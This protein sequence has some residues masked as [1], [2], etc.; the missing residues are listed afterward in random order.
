M[1][2]AD[3]RNGLIIACGSGAVKILEIQAPGGKRM[4][5]ED[6]L[7]GHTIATGTSLKEDGR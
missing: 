5:P 4:R 3:P 1:I 2:E 7:R 6:Y